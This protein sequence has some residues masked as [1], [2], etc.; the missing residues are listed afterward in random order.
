MRLLHCGGQSACNP[1]R[2][3]DRRL[4]RARQ[5]HRPILILEAIVFLVGDLNLTE[6]KRQRF[7]SPRGVPVGRSAGHDDSRIG[8]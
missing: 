8:L 2:I 3:P 1:R 6:P 7:D 5:D 4:A